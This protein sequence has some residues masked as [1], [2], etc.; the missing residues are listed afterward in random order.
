MGV[1]NNVKFA[2]LVKKYK[3]NYSGHSKK[4]GISLNIPD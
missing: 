3:K 4:Y 1:H 2:D